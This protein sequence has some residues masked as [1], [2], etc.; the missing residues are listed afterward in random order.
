MWEF[1]TD[2]LIA[3]IINIYYGIVTKLYL[4]KHQ[5][6]VYAKIVS[7][8]VPIVNFARLIINTFYSVFQCDF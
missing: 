3:A 4:Y 2:I 6:C 1:K 7:F 5:I 8:N